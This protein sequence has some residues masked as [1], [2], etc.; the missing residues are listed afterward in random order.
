MPKNVGFR[1]FFEKSP[2]LRIAI[3]AGKGGLGK[4]ISSAALSYKLAMMGKKVLCFS[5]RG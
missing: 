2:G 4:T 3:F 1:Y 5:T